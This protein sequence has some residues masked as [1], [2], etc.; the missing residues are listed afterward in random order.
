MNKYDQY[1]LQTPPTECQCER[2]GEYTDNFQMLVQPGQRYGQVLCPDC[3]QEIKQAQE[4]EQQAAFAAMMED[5][6]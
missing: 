6:Q 1:K 2:C 3:Y 5:E 4:D